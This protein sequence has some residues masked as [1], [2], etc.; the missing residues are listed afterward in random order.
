MKLLWEQEEINRWIVASATI[1][2]YLVKN[3]SVIINNYAANIK[4]I[5]TYNLDY[6]SHFKKQREKGM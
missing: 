1:Y 3:C 5:D 6:T 2:F 4:S